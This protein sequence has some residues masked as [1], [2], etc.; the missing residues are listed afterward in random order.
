MTAAWTG[1]SLLAIDYH[2]NSAR[3]QPGSGWTRL[4]SLPFEFAACF[5]QATSIGDTVFV[6]YCRQ[7][8]LYDTAT[9][10][11]QRIP[12]PE[13][14]PHAVSTSCLPVAAATTVLMWC[15]NGDGSEP[16]FW[17]IDPSQTLASG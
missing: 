1:T 6:W 2:L 12:T 10:S 13:I 9:E 3:W 8:A 14:D 16:F 15:G 7:A 11:W 17:E 5:P 4:P